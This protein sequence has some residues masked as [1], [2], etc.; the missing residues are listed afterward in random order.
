VVSGGCGDGWVGWFLG[1]CGLWSD[2]RRVLF[3]LFDLWVGVCLVVLVWSSLNA[4]LEPK[5][6]FGWYVR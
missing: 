6:A 1:P 4:C 2:T 5:S 3:D